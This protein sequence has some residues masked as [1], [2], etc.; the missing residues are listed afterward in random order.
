MVRRRSGRRWRQ[1]ILNRDAIRRRAPTQR[2]RV[3]EAVYSERFATANPP[4]NLPDMITTG[5]LVSVLL[6]GLALGLGALAWLH[7]GKPGTGAGTDAA[8]TLPAPRSVAS[9]P[10]PTVAPEPAPTA[11]ALAATVRPSFDL[12][13]V[14]KN[15]DAVIAGLSGPRWR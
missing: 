9:A 4:E 12:I 15:G 8:R 5:R 6:T 2:L 10:P 7:G 1:N 11:V 13:R 3:L 14:E